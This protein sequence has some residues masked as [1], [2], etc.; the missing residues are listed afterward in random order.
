MRQTQATFPHITNEMID[1]GL[2][3]ARVERSKAV[4]SFIDS[5]FGNK[6]DKDRKSVG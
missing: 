6:E 5:I 4:L 2:R 1:A 3:R